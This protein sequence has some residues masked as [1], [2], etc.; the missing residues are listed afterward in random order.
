MCIAF[1]LEFTIFNLSS[2]KKTVI[3]ISI[4]SGLDDLD[5]PSHSDDFFSGSSVS[6]PLRNYLDRL[7]EIDSKLLVEQQACAS[8]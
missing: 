7:S 3:Y 2:F 8:E 4:G 6:H 1:Q 5:N